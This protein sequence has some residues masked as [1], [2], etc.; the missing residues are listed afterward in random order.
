M[1]D[2]S[3]GLLEKF[4]HWEKSDPARIF[5]RQPIQGVWNDYSFK[6]T[7]DEVRKVAGYLKSLSMPEGSKIAILSKNCA[8]WII[9]DIAIWMAGFVSVP[10][11]PTLTAG[12][13]RQILDHSEAKA[14]FLGKLD[15]YDAQKQGINDILHKISF[16][17]YGPEE[18]KPWN[19]ILENSAPVHDDVVRDGNDLATISYTSGTTGIPKGVMF[20]FFAIGYSTDLAF[21]AIYKEFD[22][23]QQP[24]MFS[25]LPLSH[26]A[27]RMIVEA[28][29]I[30]NGAMVSFVESLDSFARNLSETQPDIFFGVPRIWAR[31]HEKLL[32]K[33]P[34]RRLSLMLR[35]PLFNSL[36]KKKIKRNLGLSRSLVNV[37]AAAPISASLLHWY[38][39]LDIVIYE[40]YGMTENS[41]VSHANLTRKKIGTVGPPWPEVEVR[42]SDAGEI[43][44]RHKGM[45]T[46]Y[47]KEPK[48][49]A[50]M[51]TP[52]G[53]L[54]TG[55]KGSIDEEGFLTITGR[56]KDLFKTDKGK[57]VAPGPIES[58][59]MANAD[60]EQVCVVGMGI[61]QPIALI[62]LSV[63]GKIKSKEGIIQS[64]G[65]L[66]QQ[67]N[68]ALESYEKLETAVVMKATWTV[69]NGLMTPTLKV[70]RNE[71][72]KIHLPRYPQWYH[73]KG[74]VVWE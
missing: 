48:L 72:E 26:I 53:F 50:E 16:E 34:Q 22:L 73:E 51:F 24:R 8:H 57:Y 17:F 58:K 11:Y 35:I 44:T 15:N 12:T 47:Y 52:D 10:L 18:G 21:S 46:G 71:V 31:F 5:L 29:G 40:F 20:T 27:E 2:P 60:I 68:E 3:V 69:E 4:Y 54:K 23:P 70:K 45:M 65:E 30:Y 28:G 41:G 1:N 37:S 61:P 25:Y 64:L 7:G 39:T 43:L 13:I 63:A 49:T 19:E 59:L 56:I 74:L 62:V 32:E 66:I 33:I 9:A 6:K 55:D 42:L 38:R 67:V 14:I 36:L